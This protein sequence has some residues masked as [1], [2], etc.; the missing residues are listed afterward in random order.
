MPKSALERDRRAKKNDIAVSNHVLDEYFR[1]LRVD[2]LGDLNA[3]RQ[4]KLALKVEPLR[5]VPNATVSAADLDDPGISV[6]PVGAAPRDQA[7]AT[8]AALQ[9]ETLAVVFH[10]VGSRAGEGKIQMCGAFG[11][12]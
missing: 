4:R 8:A 11:G 3:H 10:L 12:T 2:M 1:G 5:K 6:A 7:D 9:A